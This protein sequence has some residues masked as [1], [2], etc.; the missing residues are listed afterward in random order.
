MANLAAIVG[1][2]GG[3][4]IGGP[5]GAAAGAALGSKLSG[6]SDENALKDGLSALGLAYSPIGS[7]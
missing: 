5:A 3:F 7:A 1:G 6:S 2:I 4:F